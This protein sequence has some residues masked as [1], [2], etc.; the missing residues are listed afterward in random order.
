MTLTMSLIMFKSSNISLFENCLDP[1]YPASEK[2]AE[3]DIQVFNLASKSMV[4][5]KLGTFLVES[6]K[7]YS[8]IN[9][10]TV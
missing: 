6:W 7:D 5:L 3:Q 9:E 4:K 10:I 2:P 1:V 8:S